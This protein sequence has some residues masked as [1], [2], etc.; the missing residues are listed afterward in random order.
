MR[1]WR[2]RRRGAA[3]LG[4]F[5]LLLQ[6]GFAFGHVHVDAYGRAPAGAPSWLKS[7]IATSH[8]QTPSGPPDD[9][10]PICTAMQMAASGLLPAPPLADGPS[11]YALTLRQTFVAE[12]K[13]G[14]ARHTLFQTR[15]PPIA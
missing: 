1:G 6:L 9:D 5:A 15:A 3:W 4:L 13:V 12:F 7:N 8:G 11:A 14:L 10:C 2:A